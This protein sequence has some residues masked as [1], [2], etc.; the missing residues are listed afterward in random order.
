MQIK[1]LIVDVHHKHATL[2]HEEV[3]LREALDLM[4]R[5]ALNALVVVNNKDQVVGVLSSQDI[6]AATLPSEMQENISL[7]EAM[8]QEGFFEELCQQLGDKKVKD[9]MRK[10]YITVDP[11]TPILEILADFLHHDL[12]A[13]PVINDK[14]NTVGILTRTDIKKAVGRGM[15]IDIRKPMKRLRLQ[16]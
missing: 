14:Q 1:D 13:V 8:Y 4:I 15:G 5:R 3:S 6:A 16:R 9:V 12:Y 2:I 10:D 7:T 11:H